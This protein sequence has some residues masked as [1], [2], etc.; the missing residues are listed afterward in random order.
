MTRTKNDGMRPPAKIE[1]A[2]TEILIAGDNDILKPYI[3][4][5]HYEPENIALAPLGSV[6]GI[7][8]IENHNDDSAYI[9]NFLASVAKK[10]YFSHPKRPAI[11]SLEATLHKINLA[12]SELIKQDN[13]SW[14]GKLNATICVFEK[15]N[16]H[17][18]VSGRAKVL[19]IR[20]NILN[21]ISE[22]LAEESDIHPLK[23]FIEVSSGRL[24]MNDKILLTTPG[25]FEIFSPEEIQKNATRFSNEKF[26]QFLKTALVNQLLFG[27]TLI[28]DVFDAQDKAPILTQSAPVETERAIP[29]GFSQTTFSETKKPPTRTT[30]PSNPSQPDQSEL[31][32]QESEYTDSKTGHIYVQG[33]E[34]AIRTNE[35]WLHMQWVIEEIFEKCTQFFKKFSGRITK[36][37]RVFCSEALRSMRTKKELP[38]STYEKIIVTEDTSTETTSYESFTPSPLSNTPPLPYQERVS[39]FTRQTLNP[40]NIIS[41]IVSVFPIIKNSAVKILPRFSVIRHEFS[42]LS[43]R[44]KKMAIIALFLIFIIPFLIIKFQ[45]KPKVPSNPT[46]NAT[47]LAIPQPLSEDKNIH[48]VPSVSSVFTDTSIITTVL[49]KDALFAITK[50]SVVNLQNP[51]STQVFPLPQVFGT[52]IIHATAMNDLNTIFLLT[53]TGKIIS[54]TPLNHAFTENSIVLPATSDITDI[55]T[56]LT[57][58]YIIDSNNDTISRYPRATGGFGEASAWLKESID[59]QSTDSMAI[60]ED[61]YLAQND[62]LLAFNRGRRDTVTFE[63]SATPIVFSKVFTQTNTQFV[64]VL[65]TVNGRLVQFEKSGA[66]VNQYAHEN[67]KTAFSLTVDEHT[68]EAYFTSVSEVFSLHLE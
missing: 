7:F 34:P 17:F 52:A 39:T 53:D 9:V 48:K 32:P 24:K 31:T 21:D 23:T 29:N 3:Q 10:E 5:F 54:F 45:G 66:I 12:L 8:E 63:T 62:Q 13:T 20:D 50:N 25:L 11:E 65:D 18:S 19:L 41:A 37:I 46:E 61:L 51:Q 42:K 1:I 36:T 64:Y 27:S 44:H 6:F 33:D 67:I 57:Y 55:A 22:G 49:L 2:T 26:S 40:R 58:L 59:I 35:T 14:L 30:V 16:I 28:V 68:K 56:Y 47:P 43:A 60:N 15:S 4:T 38:P